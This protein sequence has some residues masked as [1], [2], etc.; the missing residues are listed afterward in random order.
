MYRYVTICQ[1]GAD[2]EGEVKVMSLKVTNNDASL[3]RADEDDISYVSF[4][5]ILE[6]L[7]NPSLI[8]KRNRIYY[9][10]PKRLGVFEKF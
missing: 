6:I 9:E 1:S 8:L 2:E 4:E 10:F 3:F 5:D 7:P